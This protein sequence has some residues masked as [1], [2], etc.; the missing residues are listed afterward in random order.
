LSAGGARQP[1]VSYAVIVVLG[2]VPTALITRFYGVLPNRFVIRWDSFGNV[3]IIGTRP[4]TI[5]MIANV[6]A[7]IALTAVVLSIWQ[8]KAMLSLGM[9]RAFLAL[10]L[11]QIVAINLVCAMIVSDALG[12]GLTFKPMVPAAMAVSIFAAGVLCR[13]M[14][15]SRPNTWARAAAVAL[16]VAG[17]SFLAYSAIG[18]HA[19]VGYYASA[20]A[21]VAM[22]AVALPAGK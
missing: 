19:V 11:S 14:D 20:I 16:L 3:T 7:V 5:L 4:G 15:Q 13:R 22:A 1:L 6:A 2:L 18:A 12:M 10:N 8:Q 21:L 9:R 17:P